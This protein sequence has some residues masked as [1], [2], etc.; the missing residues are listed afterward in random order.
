MTCK[1]F[2]KGWNINGDHT[3]SITISLKDPSKSTIS[4]VSRGEEGFFYFPDLAAGLYTLTG[5]DV[6]LMAAR[7]T[8]RLG[9]DCEYPVPVEGNSVNNL[10]DMAWLVAYETRGDTEYTEARVT[11]TFYARDY[12]AYKGNFDECKSWFAQTFPKSDWNTRSWVNIEMPET[13]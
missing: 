12:L 8:I 6:E 11:T 7:T 5:C 4:T 1:G 10:G 13:Q 3:K 9:F 2:P